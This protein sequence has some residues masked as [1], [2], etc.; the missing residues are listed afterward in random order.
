MQRGC[1]LIVI[2]SG[3]RIHAARGRHIEDFPDAP[4][5]CDQGCWGCTHT[6][7]LLEIHLGC[8]EK[9]L[10]IVARG[11]AGA[12]LRGNGEDILPIRTLSPPTR[13]RHPSKPPASFQDRGESEFRL[14][15]QSAVKMVTLQSPKG[16]GPELQ[17]CGSPQGEFPHQVPLGDLTA[18]WLQAEIDALKSR[19]LAG[20]ASDGQS[21]PIYFQRVS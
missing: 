9:T 4:D 12:D 10:S 7:K 20:A 18:G 6:G 2:G 1:L 3:I 15:P 5:V 13:R 11:P 17:A 16:K 21:L 19:S 8:V 14:F